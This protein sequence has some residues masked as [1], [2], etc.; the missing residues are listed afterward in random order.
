MN[1]CVIQVNNAGVSY[2]ELE[3]NSVDHAES[4]M[5]TNFYGPKLLIQALLPLFR[6]SSSSI[7]RVLNVSSRLGSLDVHFSTIFFLIFLL[8]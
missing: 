1:V 8:C 5:K 4:V 7:T 2:N 3:E 6:R